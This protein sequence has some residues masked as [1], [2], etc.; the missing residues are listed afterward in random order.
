MKAA[1]LIG[2]TLL[3]ATALV[4][5][6]PAP[7]ASQTQSSSKMVFTIPSPGASCP[8]SMHALQGSGSGLLAVKNQPPVS[9]VAQHIHLVLGSRQTAKVASAK[10]IVHG[11]SGKSRMEQASS[12]QEG[13][14]TQTIIVSFTPEDNGVAADLMLQ[15]F[16]AVSSI[17]LQSIAYNDGSTWKVGG[18]Q[19]CRVAPDP[20]MLVSA[21]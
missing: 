18:A 6:S 14:L 17:R 16:T 10:V 2:S 3:A 8:V 5:Q 11:Y 4:A 13:D 12:N 21:H 7:N 15:G 19:M 20:L 1:L 9:G